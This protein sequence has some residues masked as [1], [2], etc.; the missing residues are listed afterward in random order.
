[1]TAENDNWKP[2]LKIW[3]GSNIKIIKAAN[4]SVLKLFCLFERMYE[5][6]RSTAIIVARVTE[7]GIPV[8]IINRSSPMMV[9]LMRK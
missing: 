4:A 7:G 1:M 3:V 6:R 9:E 5:T 8:I 2:G